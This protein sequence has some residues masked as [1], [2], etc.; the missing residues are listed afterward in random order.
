VIAK[1]ITLPGFPKRKQRQLFCWKS[2]AV[3]LCVIQHQGT[4]PNRIVSLPVTPF[5]KLT[6]KSFPDSTLPKLA[7]WAVITVVG[8]VLG[9]RPAASGAAAALVTPAGQRRSV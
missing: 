8:K 6:R 2:T 1:S 4:L 7:S 9:N 3:S 5:M